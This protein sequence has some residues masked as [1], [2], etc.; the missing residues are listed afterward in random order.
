MFSG[1]P[2]G[3][4][5]PPTLDILF[6]VYCR[7]PET[8]WN[9]VSQSSVNSPQL[10]L[11]GQK[12]SQLDAPGVQP[13][14]LGWHGCVLADPSGCVTYTAETQHL[15]WAGKGR[16]L[17]TLKATEEGTEGGLRSGE[18]IRLHLFVFHLLCQFGKWS[19]PCL[20]W[21]FL[22]SIS[23]FHQPFPRH[24]P[25]P[26]TGKRPCFV[27]SS[28]QL[29]AG[30]WI[31]FGIETS[32]DWK[33]SPHFLSQW[34]LRP[35]PTFLAWSVLCRASSLLKSRDGFGVCALLYLSLPSEDE[36]I[37]TMLLPCIHN[38]IYI[39]FISPALYRLK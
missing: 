29:R 32:S 24:Y 30:C 33:S 6:A 17:G 12:C 21:G 10:Y 25:Q 4:D 19:L 22:P 23:D 15:S 34:H 3:A 27:Y 11:I 37:V 39:S 36:Q 14:L 1:L 13:I 20:L 31:T 38:L 2:L 5:C 35:V 16:T 18:T 8:R 9:L 28:L 26:G 7:V